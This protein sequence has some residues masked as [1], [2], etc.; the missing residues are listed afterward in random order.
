VIEYEV[1]QRFLFVQEN[2]PPQ[3]PTPLVVVLNGLEKLKR[4]AP[5]D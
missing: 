5:R 2:D 3:E 1:G 4:L